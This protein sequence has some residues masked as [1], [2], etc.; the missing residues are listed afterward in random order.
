MGGFEEDGDLSSDED[1][2][3]PDP[4]SYPVDY[5]EALP[6]SLDLASSDLAL[7]VKVPAI[8]APAVGVVGEALPDSLDLASSDLALAV[9]VPAIPAPAV[10]VVGEALPDSLDL[11][12]SDLALEVAVPSSALTTPIFALVFG[13]VENIAVTPA[14]ET[15]GLESSTEVLVFEN[16]V[17]VIRGCINTV[18]V[19]KAAPSAPTFEV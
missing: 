1:P 13:V 4:F 2:P 9:K 12:S 8:P 19:I 14:L 17:F 5:V 16:N 3:S 7:A 11:A 18:D 10:G 15:S 6:D